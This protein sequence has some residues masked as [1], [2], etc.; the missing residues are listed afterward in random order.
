MHVGYQ[1]EYLKRKENASDDD[2]FAYI[3]DVATLQVKIGAG[4]FNALTVSLYGSALAL[5]MLSF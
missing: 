1:L 3:G 4:A 2:V 5:A